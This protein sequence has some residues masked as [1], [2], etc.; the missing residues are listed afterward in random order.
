MY[1]VNYT[2]ILMN[3]I[4]EADSSW[5]VQSCKYGYEFDHSEIPYTTIATEVF[6]ELVTVSHPYLIFVC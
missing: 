1:N 5:T 6:D 2:E 4:T 3:N